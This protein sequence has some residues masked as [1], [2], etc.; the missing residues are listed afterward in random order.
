MQSLVNAAGKLGLL[1]TPRPYGSIEQ[2]VTET[3]Q[4]PHF[5]NSHFVD[6]C[7]QAG[8]VIPLLDSIGG[9][10]GLFDLLRTTEISRSQR[11]RLLRKVRELV[12][13]SRR[14]LMES[15]QINI[16]SVLRNHIDELQ[17]HQSNHDPSSSDF[18]S[19]TISKS[20]GGLP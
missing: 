5:R 20:T 8:G 19:N 2:L 1:D 17:S 12:G 14:L 16:G 13:K 11:S 15:S 10:D 6:L 18:V 7:A 9:Y 4:A 3:F